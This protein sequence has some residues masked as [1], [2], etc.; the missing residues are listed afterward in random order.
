MLPRGSWRIFFIDRYMEYLSPKKYSAVQEMVADTSS[1]QSC[2]CRAH[3]P[4][5]VAGLAGDVI[6]HVFMASTPLLGVCSSS[7][8]CQRGMLLGRRFPYG[9]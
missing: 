9:R 4:T 8:G 3:A 7:D 2:F 6:E 1:W 5:G